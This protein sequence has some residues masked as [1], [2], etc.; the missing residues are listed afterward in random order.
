MGKMGRGHLSLWNFNI[1]I[2][3]SFSA[4]LSFNDAI[5]QFWL[6][7]YNLPCL[8]EWLKQVCGLGML[9]SEF[10]HLIYIFAF[11]IWDV[12]SWL[13][14]FRKNTL[15]TLCRFADLPFYTHFSQLPSIYLAPLT[16][17]FIYLFATLSLLK[18]ETVCHWN[19]QS[20][21]LKD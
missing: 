5:R 19:I 3:Y 13:V 9:S 12:L 1:F 11:L 16:D 21:K 10:V 14:N 17:N 15:N 20:K 7:T 2:S 8:W 18:R 4:F 6:M